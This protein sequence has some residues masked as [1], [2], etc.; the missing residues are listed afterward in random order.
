MREEE[1]GAAK[2]AAGRAARRGWRPQNRMLDVQILEEQGVTEGMGSSCKTTRMTK[3]RPKKKSEGSSFEMACYADVEMAKVVTGRK[4][5]M[6]NSLLN[7][8]MNTE[9]DKRRGHL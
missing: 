9:E 3:R 8:S 5:K 2:G 1:Q 4:M 7:S 6:V